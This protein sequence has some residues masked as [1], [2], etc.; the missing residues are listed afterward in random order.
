MKLA[1]TGQLIYE[2]PWQAIAVKPWDDKYQRVI[3]PS[4][5]PYHRHS[6]QIVLKANIDYQ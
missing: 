5:N 2:L 1:S 6:I 3:I 4:D